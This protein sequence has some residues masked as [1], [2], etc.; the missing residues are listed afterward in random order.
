MA[1]IFLITQKD[2]DRLFLLV[3]QNPEQ[4][5]GGSNHMSDEQR[6]IYRD[7]HRFY[8]YNVRKWVDEIVK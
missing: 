5:G 2:L 7:A 1:K 6:N 3:D 8:N 4:Y